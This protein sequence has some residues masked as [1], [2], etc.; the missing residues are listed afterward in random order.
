MIFNIHVFSLVLSLC[1]QYKTFELSCDEVP[2]LEGL[3]MN[4]VI[5]SEIKL[6]A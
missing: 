4:A 3:G 6:I 2:T 1:G 5:A